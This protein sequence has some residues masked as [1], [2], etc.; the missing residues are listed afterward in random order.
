[1]LTFHFY[2]T[3]SPKTVLAI[4]NPGLV[5]FLWE[6][7]QFYVFFLPNMCSTV[8]N[9]QYLDL[10]SIRQWHTPLAAHWMRGPSFHEEGLHTLTGL[11]S[12]NARFMT[13]AARREHETLKKKVQPKLSLSLTGSLCRSSVSTPP[14]HTSGNL[15]PPVTPPIT[16]SSSFRSSTPTGTQPSQT[17]PALLLDVEC[18]DCYVLCIVY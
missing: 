4:I 13:D 8:A 16:P 11:L 2:D 3:H 9:L 1:M 7:S 12:H 17:H 15:T 10:V 14:R 6:Q 18:S 5:V